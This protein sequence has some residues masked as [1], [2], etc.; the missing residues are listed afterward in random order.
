MTDKLLEY[1]RLEQEKKKIETKLEHLNKDKE[2]QQDMEFKQQIEAVLETYHKTRQDLLKLFGPSKSE[3][4]KKPARQKESHKQLLKCYTNPHTQE[5]VEARSLRN[6]TLQEW[7]KQ[8][9]EE[10]VKGWAKEIEDKDS[11]SQQS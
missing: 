11:S 2:F 10:T 5:T 9:G 8:H 1:E 3:P 7:K 6:T 4:S